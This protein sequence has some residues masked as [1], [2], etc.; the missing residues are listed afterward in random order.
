MNQLSH[1]PQHKQ[2]ELAEI[3]GIICEIT[4]P[5][6]VILF[7]SHA[8]GKWVEDEYVDK[9]TTYTYISDYDILVVLS[10]ADKGDEVDIVSKIDNRTGKYKNEVSAI[11]HTISY[12]NSGLERGQYF[13]S[14]IVKEGI[15]LYDSGEYTFVESKPLTNEQLKQLAIEDFNKWVKSGSRFLKATKLLY[16]E[17]LADKLPLNEVVFI[18]NQTAEKFYGGVLLVYTGYK[19]KT[20]RIRAYR[21]YAKH[22]SQ[23]LYNVFRYPRT[24]SEENRLFKILNDAY[25]DARYKDDYFIDPDDLKKLISRVDKLE[26]VVTRL[27]EERISQL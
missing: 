15:T 1:L 21:K 8:T 5:A 27:C 26:D 7:G 24:D 13:F 23:D 20:H 16:E 4:N 3:V 10:D 17:F 2:N 12:I 6:K 11:V 14:D 19:P 22:I 9:G 18:L 25:I